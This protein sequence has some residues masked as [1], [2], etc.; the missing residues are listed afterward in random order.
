[1]L[2]KVLLDV[3]A[4]PR[5]KGVLEYRPAEAKL[6]CHACRLVYSIQDDIPVMLIDEAE[7]LEPPPPGTEEEPR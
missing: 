3:L 7:P 2:D 5:C 4:C 6:I 1:M